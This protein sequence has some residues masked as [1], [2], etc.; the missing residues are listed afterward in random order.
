[1]I[2]NYRDLYIWIV[3]RNLDGVTLID[4]CKALDCGLLLCVARA[5][6]V[7]GIREIHQYFRKIA[8]F[9][10]YQVIVWCAED[11]FVLISDLKQLQKLLPVHF[12]DSLQHLLRTIQ[13][14]VHCKPLLIREVKVLQIR[15]IY[16][17]P[18]FPG[19][20]KR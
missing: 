11:F 8:G 2:F 14:L 16:L 10:R 19:L 4:F 7:A 20:R 15:I 13:Q 18:L 6:P 1:M 12:Q 17:Q 5:H 3:I 9:I